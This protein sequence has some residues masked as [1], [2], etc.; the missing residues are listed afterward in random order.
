MDAFAKESVR[1]AREDLVVGLAVLCHDLGKPE[2][3]AFERERLRSIR[4]EPSGEEPT[5]KFLSAMTNST[6]LIDEV[7]ALVVHHLKPLQLYEAKAGDAAI[8]R[9]AVKVK[10]IDRLVRVARADQQGRPP[11]P[12]DGFPAGEWLSD[13]ARVLEV[14][15]SAPRPIVKGRHLIELGMV[16]GPS[17]GPLLQKCY[18]AQIEGEISNRREGIAFVRELL[19]KT[20]VDSD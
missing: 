8:R 13:R 1:D 2:T 4:H 18:E 9:L 17:F 7:V 3:T 5:R 11:M 10:R 14:R 19:L 15:A 12:F 20:D 16:P 6:D